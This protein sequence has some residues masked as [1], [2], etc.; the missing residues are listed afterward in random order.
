[1]V[2]RCEDVWQEVS[3]YLEGEG[4]PELR[5]AI[6]E[7]IRGCQHCAAV[8]DGTRNV[9]QLYGDERMIEVPL[10][11]SQ[12]L[13]RR[14]EENMPGRATRRSFMGW[15]V[16][17]AAAV[18]TV[19]AVNLASS[20]ALGKPHP[21][22]EHAQSGSGIPPELMVVVSDKGRVFHLA[23]CTFIH[24]RN[25]LRS[26]PARDAQQQGFVPCVRCLRQYLK[27]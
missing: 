16:A 1:M 8:L 12:R 4:S 17:A 13:H 22:T 20:S 7:H 26:I 11:Y 24:D 21:R 10:G 18:V 23:A 19:G 25:N 15:M 27:S 3:N 2:M 14:L 6:E 5:A 9:V